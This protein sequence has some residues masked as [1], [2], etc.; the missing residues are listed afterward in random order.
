MHSQHFG[1]LSSH[2]FRRGRVAPGHRASRQQTYSTFQA[3]FWLAT[4][5][6]GFIVFVLAALHH[7]FILKDG[8]L[9]RMVFGG[10]ASGPLMRQAG[11]PRSN[12]G[13]HK[14]GG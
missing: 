11:G 3:H 5:L 9:R 7:Q 4:L 6:V 12:E 2:S 1:V 10:R 8:L 13:I 14:D